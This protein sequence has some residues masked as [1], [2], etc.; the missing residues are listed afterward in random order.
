MIRP[1][2]AV[3]IWIAFVGGMAVYTKAR[4][5]TA[6]PVTHERE[7]A[8]EAYSLEVTTTF[9][10]E[11]DPFALKD[12][13]H[14]DAAGLVIRLNGKE[15]VRKTGELQP[16]RPFRVAPV[17]GLI[18][19][20]NEFY[21]QAFPPLDATDRVQGV[22]VRVFRD[23]EVVLDRALWSEPGTSIASTFP[24]SVGPAEASKGSADEH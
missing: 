13:D 8:R 16:G 15:I 4:Q 17:N 21:L 1:V 3:A 5:E 20:N 19:G 14:A 22:R 24:L 6:P 10:V 18:Q 9:A 23:A 12:A 11:P 2:F 7:L